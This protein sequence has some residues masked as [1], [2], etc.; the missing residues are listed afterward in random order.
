MFSKGAQ[1]EWWTLIKIENKLSWTEHA[2]VSFY[3]SFISFHLHDL[4]RVNHYWHTTNRNGL[5]T[6]V[7]T[8]CRATNNVLLAIFLQFRPSTICVITQFSKAVAAFEFIL[9]IATT[10]MPAANVINDSFF[11]LHW[12]YWHSLQACN[13]I[14]LHLSS[15]C[16]NNFFH[17]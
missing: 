11:V 10:Y 3:L 16:S 2:F 14:F 1:T 8:I 15:L 9:L 13:E 7:T 12:N 4:Y 6:N 5:Q 17:N